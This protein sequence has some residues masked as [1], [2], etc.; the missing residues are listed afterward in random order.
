MGTNHMISVVIPLYNKKK[1]IGSTL[2]SVLSQSYQ[3]FEILVVDDG[4]T[5]GSADVVRHYNDQ[6]IR[7]ITKVNGGV[8]S[9]RNEGIRHAQSDY[10]AFLDADDLWEPDF[11]AEINSLISDFPDAGIY[12]TS[13][14]YLKHGEKVVANKPVPDRY[15]GVIDNTS[16]DI[17]HLY[18]SSAVCCK[19]SELKRIGLFDERIAYGEDI[20]VWWQIMLNSPA[21]YS[22]KALATY[23]FDEENRAMNNSIPLDKLYIYYFEK[24]SRYRKDNIAF[25]HFIDQECMWWLFNYTGHKSEKGNISRILSQIDLSEYKASFRFRFKHPLIYR[26]IKKLL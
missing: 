16:W 10:I 2:D 8:S 25:R 1:C 18:C 19:L 7:L 24:Y 6:R 9:A 22:N 13:Y 5:D 20:D 26:T 4:S 21:A 14:H 12:G 17:A 23:R 3:D 11:L 15:Y